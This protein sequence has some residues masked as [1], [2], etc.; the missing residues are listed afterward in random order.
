M[1]LLAPPSVG[2][3]AIFIALATA[4]PALLV[5]TGKR[6]HQLDLLR[7]NPLYGITAEHGCVLTTMP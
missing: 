6:Q 4:W 7:Q 1:W 5:H 2:L 3:L